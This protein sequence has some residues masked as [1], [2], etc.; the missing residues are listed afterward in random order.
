MDKLWTVCRFLGSIAKYYVTPTPPDFE[1]VAVESDGEDITPGF[2]T[3]LAFEWAAD[4]T[5][6][7]G[8]RFLITYK[9]KGKGPYQIYF[10]EGEEITYPPVI[11]EIK[12]VDLCIISA[13]VLIEDAEDA[14]D[15]TE[16][17]EMLAG[18]DG[19]FNGRNVV[20]LDPRLLY[21]E[22][23]K[24]DVIVISYVNGD[25]IHIKGP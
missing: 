21:S 2:I 5:W 4:K 24:G 23:K 7:A 25:E 9:H 8:K 11:T 12:P 16:R 18:P 1:I 14:L 15:I 20:S 3:W 10:D 13:E 22:F 19:K 6:E 17:A